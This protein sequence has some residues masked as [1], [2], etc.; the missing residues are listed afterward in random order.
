MNTSEGKLLFLSSNKCKHTH[1]AICSHRC[2][3]SELRDRADEKRTM[4][5]LR[6][7]R[8]WLWLATKRMRQEMET[9]KK[10]VVNEHVCTPLLYTCGPR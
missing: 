3:S 2:V 1:P 6:V 5:S 10:P 4:C 7:F 9:T 8:S